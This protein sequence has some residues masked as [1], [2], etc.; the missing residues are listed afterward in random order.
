MIDLAA[1]QQPFPNL[2]SQSHSCHSSLFAFTQH[3]FVFLTNASTFSI[4]LASST[5]LASALQAVISITHILML[6]TIGYVHVQATNYR[7]HIEKR[8]QNRTIIIDVSALE[9]DILVLCPFVLSPSIRFVTPTDG[10]YG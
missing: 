3:S 5:A 2:P 9:S 10:R 4:Q 1:Q 8:K 6:N 7:Y